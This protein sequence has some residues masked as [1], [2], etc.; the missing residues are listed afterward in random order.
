MGI[1]VLLFFLFIVVWLV[2]SEPGWKKDRKRTLKRRGRKQ[3]Y[4]YGYRRR[5]T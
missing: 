3:S 2:A 5:R 1:V 4:Q